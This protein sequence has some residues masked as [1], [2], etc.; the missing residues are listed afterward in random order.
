M[1]FSWFFFS[2]HKQTMHGQTHIKYTTD[3]ILS[4][5]HT[6]WNKCSDVCSQ[7]ANLMKE[8]I[9]TRKKCGNNLCILHRHAL[10]IK[11]KTNPLKSFPIMKLTGCINFSYLFLE[12]NSTY[13]GQILC[14]SS[15]VFHCTHSNNICHTGL[16]RACEQD[17]DGTMVPSWHL[18]LLCVQ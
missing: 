13:F 3:Q 4:N 15:R 2:T 6:K 8:E 14:P 10:L 17:Q 5:H 9:Y 12:W 7:S 11:M 1:I 16:L 18:P